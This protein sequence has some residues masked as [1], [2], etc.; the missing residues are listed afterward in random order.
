MAMFINFCF[1]PVHDPLGLAKRQNY[2][3]VLKFSGTTRKA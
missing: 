2:R 3:R 1:M